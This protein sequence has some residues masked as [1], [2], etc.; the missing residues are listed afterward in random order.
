MIRSSSPEETSV[1]PS[2]E[3]DIAA[4]LS[5]WR[6]RVVPRRAT[7]PPGRRSPN[8]SRGALS[9]GSCSVPVPSRSRNI[10]QEISI[11]LKR[12]YPSPSFFLCSSLIPAFSLQSGT[13]LSSQRDPHLK[14]H[15]QSSPLIDLLWVQHQLLTERA[16][17]TVT[18]P[19]QPSREWPQTDLLVH[20][21]TIDLL[22]H[23]Q[24]IRPDWG[25]QKAPWGHFA[26]YLCPGCAGLHCTLRPK[27]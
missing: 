7:T 12:P 17:K 27:P 1:F 8:R 9:P 24:K 2:G 25:P 5:E 16:G 15:D 10:E 4:I 22:R 11:T 18:I 20:P 21:G 14:C 19:P 23:Q 6:S 26:S 3:K 13:I